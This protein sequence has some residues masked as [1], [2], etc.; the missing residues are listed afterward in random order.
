MA[1]LINGLNVIAVIP[2]L[3]RSERI[4]DK[5]TLDFCGKPLVSWTI[6]QAKE[7]NII[8]RVYIITDDEQVQRISDQYGA[9]CLQPPEDLVARNTPAKQIIPHVLEEIEKAGEKNPD[10]I[11]FLRPDHPLRSPRYIDEAVSHLLKTSSDFLISVTVLGDFNAWRREGTGF[12]CLTAENR[13]QEIYLENGSLYV[14]RSASLWRSENSGAEK[15]AF[16]A[17]PLWQSQA[18]ET[19]EDL[20]V[21]GY[22]FSR[23]LL[24]QWQEKKWLQSIPAASIDLIVYDFDGVM[25]DN[26][27]IV[28]QDGTEAV[29]ANR[30]DGLGVNRLSALGIPQLILS[31]EANPVV[32]ARAAKLGLEVIGSCKDKKITLQNYCEGKNYDLNRV[33]YLGN[34]VNDLEAMQMVGF[35]IAPADAHPE[36]KAV[37]KLVT[38]ARGGEGV[39][40]E[41]AERVAVAQPPVRSAS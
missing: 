26:R 20:E 25:T 29:V 5:I 13:G 35:P 36:V 4:P 39:I 37:A 31:T 17:M 30:A 34:D 8:T 11:V 18:M 32:E 21:Y 15:I 22:Y 41:L 3:G 9:I 10:I 19:E 12:K 40:K 28:W 24:P 16:W 1:E 7:S 2:A 38:T 27:V 6:K 33:V 23:K 14:F